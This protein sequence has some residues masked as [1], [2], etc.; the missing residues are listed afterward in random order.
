MFKR[1]TRRARPG[2]LPQLLLAENRKRWGAVSIRR[3]AR[4]A[5][6]Q[7]DQKKLVGGENHHPRSA[8]TRIAKSALRRRPQAKARGRRGT[9]LHTRR[10]ASPVEAEQERIARPG[11]QSTRAIGEGLQRWWR[12]DALR[13]S[14]ASHS[15]VEHGSEADCAGAGFRR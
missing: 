4:Q 9:P 8:G 3:H 7:R 1:W 5:K 12:V 2:R 15:P 14:A 11:G 10:A 6:R 13:R